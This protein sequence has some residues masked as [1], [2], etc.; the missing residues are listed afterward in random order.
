MRLERGKPYI[1]MD[2]PD[3]DQTFSSD[4][5]TRNLR[6]LSEN[7]RILRLHSTV[8]NYTSSHPGSNEGARKNI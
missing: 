1:Q 7:A 8:F 2:L 3:P 4:E 5:I 6:L